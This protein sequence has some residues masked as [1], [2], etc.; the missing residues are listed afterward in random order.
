MVGLLRV[1]TGDGSE[2]ALLSLSKEWE[3]TETKKPNL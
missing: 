3:W 2:R 1:V